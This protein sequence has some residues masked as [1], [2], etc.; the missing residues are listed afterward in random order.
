MLAFFP[1]N[2]PNTE[3]HHKIETTL[4]L[5]G[6]D[7]QLRRIKPNIAPARHN[8]IGQRQTQMATED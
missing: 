7:N 8:A 1:P 3:Y 4:H 6:T 2:F 5:R